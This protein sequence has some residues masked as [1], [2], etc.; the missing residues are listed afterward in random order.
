MDFVNDYFK[1][2]TN[3]ITFIELKKGARINIKGY[4][5][6]KDIPLPILTDVLVS[7]IIEG[8]MEEEIKVS[9][10][11]DGII[12]LMGIDSLFMHME[13]YKN[14]LMY[15]NKKAEDYIFYQGI[16]SIEEDDYDNGAVY[17]RALKYINPKNVNGIFNY[18]IALEEIGKKY[19]EKEEH[20]KGIKFLDKSTNELETIL[21]IDDKYP[22]AY[23]KLGYHYKFSEQYLKAKLI[24]TKYL[25][26]DKDELRLQEIRGEIE[27]I[28]NDVALETGLTYLS[29]EYFD[30]ALDIFLKLLPKLDK[31]WELKYLI[32]VC[33]KGLSDFENAIDYFEGALELYKLDSNLYNELG[34]CLFTIG[35]INNAIDV[36]TEG[37]E[38]VPDDYKLIF[39]RGLCYLQLGKLKDAYSDIENAVMLNPND[40]NMNTQKEALE[41][42]M[43]K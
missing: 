34:I 41:K 4:P 28:E 38:S 32:G 13:D 11:I 42:L 5:I 22:L 26:L 23:Y 31:W 37:I 19:F 10:I 3:K 2:K 27:L 8:N 14:I 25:V 33:Y 35:D 21:D 17:F 40:I 18:A 36:F 20:E 9:D 39:N 43:N 6:D 7:E 15:Y 30:K 1:K 12:Y 29:R 24:W 16:R